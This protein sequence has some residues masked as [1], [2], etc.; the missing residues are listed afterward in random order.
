MSDIAMVNILA[1][2]VLLGLLHPP[3]AQPD[4]V[5]PGATVGGGEDEPLVDDGAATGPLDAS[6]FL[7]AQEA[8][9]GEL[10]NSC[11]LS[12]QHEG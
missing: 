5:H 12:A 6:P 1:V 9:E 2:N 8:E 11:V 7:L 4:E 10:S 3:L